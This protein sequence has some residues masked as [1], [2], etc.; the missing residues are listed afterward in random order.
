MTEIDVPLPE[1][2]K[3]QLGLG[4]SLIRV[5]TEVNEA[6]LTRV[7]QADAGIGTKSYPC[8]NGDQRSG[9]YQ[10]YV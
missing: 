6:A 10:N 2:C 5:V 7:K 4:L 9:P 1:L 8:G 3:L